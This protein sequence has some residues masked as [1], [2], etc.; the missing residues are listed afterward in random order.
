[1]NKKIG[2][3]KVL[4]ALL[5]AITFIGNVVA[6]E[7]EEVD[8]IEI[9]DYEYS[10]YW[11][12]SQELMS[13]ENFQDYYNSG[14][15]EIKE[16][17]GQLVRVRQVATFNGGANWISIMSVDGKVVF[18]LD[19]T[20]SAGIGM[21][22]NQSNDW[23]LLSW[24]V[25]TRI[26]YVIRFGYQEYGSDDYYIASQILIW[27]ALGHWITPSVNVDSQIA[28]IEANINN[29]G[30]P[31]S[32]NNQTLELEYQVPFTITDT[33]GVLNKY[34]VSCPS[35]ITCSKY[36]N[37][38]TVTVDKLNF[39]KSGSIKITSPGTNDPGWIGVVFVLPGSQ[40]VAS[41]LKQDPSSD[42]KLNLK[43][44]SG[45]LKII[46]LDEYGESTIAGNVF[47]IAWDSEFNDIIGEYTTNS[48]GVIEINGYLPPGTYYVREIAVSDPYVLNEEVFEV[49]IERNKLT[50][51]VVQNDLREVY[52]ELFKIDEEEV[53]LYLDGAVFSVTD[54]TDYDIVVDKESCSVNE[55]EEGKESIQV[56]LPSVVGKNFEFNVVTGNQYIRLY[57][58]EDNTI[59]YNGV[60]QISNNENFEENLEISTEVEEEPLF[61]YL[62]VETDEYGLL[63]ISELNLT[64]A[65][66]YYYRL[67]DS[68]KVQKFT[69][70]GEED[71]LGYASLPL[72]YGRKYEVCEIE[73][74]VGYEMPLEPCKVF[75]MNIGEGITFTQAELTNKLRRIDVKLIK[76][77]SK[78]K[79]ILLNGATFKVWDTYYSTE[80]NVDGLYLG[81]YITGALFI[82]KKEI[83]TEAVYDGDGNAMFDEETGVL[84]TTEKEVGVPDIEF[85]IYSQETYLAYLEDN[86]ISP[87]HNFKTDKSGE[88][89]E[90]L[91][92]GLYYV[93]EK[94]TE[95]FE[96]YPISEGT[97]YLPE[98]K[99]GHSYQ[100]CETQQP[101][102]YHFPQEACQVLVPVAD[103]G[104]NIVDN[105]RVNDMIII[106]NTGNR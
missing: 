66:V 92:D 37:E 8:N 104:I 71:L 88:I 101:S 79:V 102:G 14:N 7:I 48:D 22:Y 100:V 33:N 27:R 84:I 2:A 55:V 28:Q 97:I 15:N 80:E 90:Y 26:W 6:E 89:V 3:G 59:P 86:T 38:L 77:D 20:V 43:M 11:T 58:F 75:D 47:E 9:N 24:D 83:L 57:D 35:G 103:Y 95:E 5:L 69:V 10:D 52:L 40:S 106:P 85:E 13:V 94:D 67:P 56:C 81:E 99:Y 68:D 4:L 31:V 34:S 39:E 32:F 16:T 50:E 74:P 23:H 63:N 64:P 51:L 96:L 19:P 87:T 41:V 53:E 18:C 17:R 70:L 30:T 93:R 42:Y 72:K 12:E 105:Y 62:E 82:Q 54:I 61:V 45:D 25:Q 46:K 60:V 29:F 44:I 1:M 73:P 36:G 91:K 98:L 49:V 65:A 76:Q 21:E 78:N